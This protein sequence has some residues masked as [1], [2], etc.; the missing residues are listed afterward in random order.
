MTDFG[1]KLRGHRENRELSLDEI[2]EST[3]I[4]KAYLDALERNDFDA[5]PG[6][7]FA[8]GYIRTVAETLGVDPESLLRDYERERQARGQ[9]NAED[10]DRAAQDA[11]QAVLSRLAGSSGPTGRNGPSGTVM[12]ALGA[13]GIALIVV[14][15]LGLNICTGT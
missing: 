9:G 2:A 5:L 8:K 15:I 13:L 3:K 1:S 11:A 14:G 10:E 7:V 12:V 6:Q 4:R